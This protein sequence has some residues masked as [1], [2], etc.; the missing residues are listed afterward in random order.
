MNKRMMILGAAAAGILSATT[1]A[2]FGAD[3]KK[4]ANPAADKGAAMGECTGVNSCKGKGECGGATHSCSGQN[5]CKGKG[6][7]KMT[8][9]DC[10]AKKGT[11]KAGTYM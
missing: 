4:G 9:K 10:L 8:E 2:S 7:V 6:W 1:S 3:A 5:A 11:W